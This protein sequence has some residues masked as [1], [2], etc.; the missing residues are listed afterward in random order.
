[1][2]ANDVRRDIGD[3]KPSQR[4]PDH[5]RDAAEGC[6]SFHADFYLAAGLFELPR[7]EGAVCGKPQVN[8]VMTDQL[9]WR[10]TLA[11]DFLL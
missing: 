1:M 8:A 10:N 4:R 2:L 6:L 5:L 7:I 11:S 3:A 9:L